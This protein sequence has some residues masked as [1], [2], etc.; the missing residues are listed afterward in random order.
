MSV[1]VDLWNDKQGWAISIGEESA[2]GPVLRIRCGESL[3][4]GL[5]FMGGEHEVYLDGVL[6]LEGDRLGPLSADTEF[7]VHLQSKGKSDA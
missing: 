4:A 7:E 2:K 6:L 5:I 1:S 3:P